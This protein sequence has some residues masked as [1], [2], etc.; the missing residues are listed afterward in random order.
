MCRGQNTPESWRQL[1]DLAHK[2]K[3]SAANM[4]CKH[5][6]KL[7]FHMQRCCEPTVP[8]CEKKKEEMEDEEYL[9]DE[10]STLGMPHAWWEHHRHHY[11]DMT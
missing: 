8:L 9:K 10:F 7:F 2:F 6:Y 4:A 3:G 5:L 11:H 1:R